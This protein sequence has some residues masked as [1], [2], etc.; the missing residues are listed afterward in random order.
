[1]GG[2]NIERA[3]MIAAA[4][5][6]LGLLAYVVLRGTR[7]AARDIVGAIEGGVV[8][9]AEGV[10]GIFGLPVTSRSKCC[11]AVMAGDAWA[12]SAHCPAS[13]YLAWAWWSISGVKPEFLKG[14]G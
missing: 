9:A 11:E 1:M 13:D 6:A 5:A 14:C 12:V 10:G 4:G 7:G 2:M 3:A 8:G